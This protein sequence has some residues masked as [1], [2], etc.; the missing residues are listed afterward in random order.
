MS[1]SN[2]SGGRAPEARGRS[3]PPLPAWAIM[4]LAMGGIGLVACDGPVE[5]D[6]GRIEDLVV[7]LE[8]HPD[9]FRAGD[10][11]SVVTTLRNPSGV[12]V[13]VDLTEGCL[14]EPTVFGP[15]DHIRPRF[16]RERTFHME[17]SCQVLE[18]AST[19]A[20]ADGVEAFSIPPGDSLVQRWAMRAWQ[21]DA[22]SAPPDSQAPEPGSHVIRL[23]T[24]S[25]LPTL[26]AVFEVLDSGY[27]WN[28]MRCGF[29]E[30]NLQ[31]TLVIDLQ[32]PEAGAGLYSHPFRVYNHTDRDIFLQ[33]VSSNGPDGGEPYRVRATIERLT[34]EGD[35]EH[36]FTDFNPWDGVHPLLLRSGECIQAWNP[37]ANNGPGGPG[38]P[39]TYRMQLEYSFEGGSGHSGYSD[40][41]VIPEG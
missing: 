26:D 27:W 10:R 14:G 3:G 20:D 23:A 1:D 25:T 41:V 34:P 22:G 18:G 29:V 35:W 2:R 32:A 40:P 4:A 17:E 9:T 7:R 13:V 30:P 6:G 24:P 8:V 38:P 11:F 15:D 21:W 37:I 33:R 5:P 31:D 39:G 16:D 28:M 19:W 36:H 12:G